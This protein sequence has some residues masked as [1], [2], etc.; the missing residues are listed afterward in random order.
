[1]KTIRL[2]M[3]L[4]SFFISTVSEITA[5]EKVIP[6]GRKWVMRLWRP[7][8][9]PYGERL[10]VYESKGDT[11]INDMKYSIISPGMGYDKISY[12]RW[13]D[14]KCWRYWQTSKRDTL[15]F[16]ES[17]QVG[18]TTMHPKGSGDEFYTI[19]EVG[20]IQGRKYWKDGDGAVWLPDIG[21]ISTEPY[22][23]EWQLM[24]GPARRLICCVEA[25]GDTLYV[26]R[27]LLYLTQTGISLAIV[28]DDVI[29][30]QS[31]DGLLVNL[32]ANIPQWSTTLYNSNG[33]CVAQKE[34][35]GSEIFLPTDSKG[36]HILVVKAGDRVVKKKI[37]LK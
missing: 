19:T 26:D 13:E 7:L 11:M 34:G 25:N 35:A 6:K 22:Y 36:T 14:S 2:L 27:S 4:V 20:E 15:V 37:A 33:V 12:V 8:Y 1:M 16:D 18:D 29:C 23:V 9:P 30:Q 24:G 31:S 17:W 21:F 3:I 10:E 5:Q 32:G 28:D